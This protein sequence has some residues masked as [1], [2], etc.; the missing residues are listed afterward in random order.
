MNHEIYNDIAHVM[1]KEPVD[2]AHTTWKSNILDTQGFESALLLAIIGALTGVDSSNY[3][4]LTLEESD[5]TADADF[6]TVDSSEVKGAFTVINADDEDQV[7]QKVGYLGIKRYIRV[8]GTYTGSSI[9]AGI[10]GVV[11]LLSHGRVKP[12]TAPDPVSAT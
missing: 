5:T 9:S 1:L 6:S 8:V 4:T 10:C 12:V 2:A 7:I 3:I 11:G